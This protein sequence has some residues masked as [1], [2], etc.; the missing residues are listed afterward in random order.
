MPA[1][2]SLPGICKRPR[3]EPRFVK[4]RSSKW[5]IT[6]TVAFAI[7]TDIMLYGLIVPVA[8]TAL[9][10]RVGIPV[11]NAQRWTSILL[12]LYGASLL[13]ASPIAGYVADRMESRKWPFLAGLVALAASTALLCVGT[14]VGFWIAGRIFQ[15][16]SAAVVW[17][18][19]LALVVD[20]IEKENLGQYLGYLGLALTLGTMIGP[21][22]GG[23]I[24]ESGGYYAVFGTAFALVGVDIILRLLVIETRHAA[25]WLTGQQT[26][27]QSPEQK[28]A[29]QSET[30]KPPL[31]RD[32][33]LVL[34]DATQRDGVDNS[35]TNAELAGLSGD[36]KRRTPATILLLSSPRLISA[37]YSYFMIAVLLTSFDSVLPLFVHDTFRWKQTGQGLIFL[38][39][40]IPELLDPLVGAFIDRF[41]NSRRYI[42]AGSFFLSVPLYVSLRFVTHDSMEQKILLCSLLGLIGLTD[43]FLMPAVFLEINDVVQAKEEKRPDVFGKGGA[44]A[45]AYG[46]S[47]SA[48]AAGCMAGPVLAGFVRDFAGWPTMAW[49]LGLISGTTGV[50]MLLTLGGWIGKRPNGHETFVE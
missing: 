49:T 2:A 34:P 30:E 27:D 7:F 24:Y 3:S 16:V 13:A 21:L 31:V 38:A 43:A 47:N 9:V 28:P 29:P 48:F 26:P 40:S 25:E 8:P 42:A 46:L 36:E 45:Q 10:H 12:A 22:V 6:V 44:M 14:T 17:T 5:F 37:F 35:A 33:P 32:D 4:L 23:V 15:G 18:V 50:P 41:P 11:G 1:F 20:T 19:G 39:L